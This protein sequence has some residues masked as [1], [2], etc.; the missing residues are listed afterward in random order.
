MATSEKTL[1]QEKIRAQ[2]DVVRQMKKD[3]KPKEE[4]RVCC[5]PSVI[6][7]TIAHLPLSSACSKVA[8]W[9]CMLP[10]MMIVNFHF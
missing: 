3:K 5:A 9:T 4:V 8:S 1:L 6:I 10:F 7:C 2:G